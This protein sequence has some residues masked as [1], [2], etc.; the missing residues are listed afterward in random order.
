MIAGSSEGV[1]GR[2]GIAGF[3]AMRALSTDFNH[4]PSEAS[5]PWDAKRD[6]F[7]L[8]DGAGALVLEELEHAKARGARIY[9]ELT[10]YGLSGDAYHTTSPDPGGD[11]AVRAMRAALARAK[12]DPSALGYVN[13]HATSTPIGDPIELTALRKLLGSATGAVSVSSTKSA[14][15]HLLGG[16]GS[17]EAIF[18]VLSLRDQ[19]APPTLNLSEPVAEA[20]G[21]DL[22]PREAKRRRIAHALSNSFGFGGT[23]AALVFSS[24]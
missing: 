4:A 16:A 2:L 7:V 15:G 6:G 13:A 9:A 24:L 22:V 21:F 20:E 3:S 19:V 10:G 8:S 17:V 1:T 14:I 5:R 11:G 23:N 12:I 18:T